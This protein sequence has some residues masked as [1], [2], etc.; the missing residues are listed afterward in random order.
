MGPEPP[1][2]SR[3]SGATVLITGGLGFIGSNLAIRLVEL[4][5]HVTLLDAMLE[6]HGGNP[7]NIEPIRECVT[8]EIGDVRNAT[9]VRRLIREQEF[10]FHLA[11][12]N[13]HV[14]G[15][16]DPFPALDVNIRGAAVLLEACRGANPEAK[17]LYTGTRGEYGTTTMPA[18]E[19]QPRNP[20][21][22]YE[23][24]SLS[25]QWLFR[26]YH[27]QHDLRSVGLCLANIYG[28]RAHMRHD[29]FGVANWFLRQSFDDTTIRIFGDG[30]FAR[31]FVYVQD[32]V[33]AILLCA[34]TEGAYG[35]T[36]NVGN[37]QPSNFRDLAERIVRITGRGRLTFVPFAA[38]R[39]ASE[40][41]DSYC[42]IGKIRRIVGWAPMTGLEEGLERTVEFYRRHKEHYW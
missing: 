11:G 24:S 39:A 10:V 13:D 4:G 27:D 15:L 19:D 17:L 16:N 14:L 42:D 18:R 20:R 34:L 7:F 36:L 5:A 33:D 26:I 30:R 12:Y 35:E 25:A 6:G 21:G 37:D 2:F 28:E 9:L 1:D 40:P 31:D 8:V 32:A 38:D 29:R 41:G 3:F 22:I 23:L